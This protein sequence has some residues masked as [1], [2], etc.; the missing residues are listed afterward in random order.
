MRKINKDILSV[1]NE[2][3]IDYVELCKGEVKNF[4]EYSA[5]MYGDFIDGTYVLKTATDAARVPTDDIVI[6]GAQGETSIIQ[7][8]LDL[9]KCISDNNIYLYLDGIIS[10]N[11]DVIMDF[12]TDK[13]ELQ[14]V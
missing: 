12:I 7:T 1:I 3:N 5:T 6:C 10:K 4:E 13:T 11:N 9:E 14:I 8:I 2:S